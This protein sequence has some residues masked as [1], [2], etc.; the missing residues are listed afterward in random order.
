MSANDDMV[1]TTSKNMRKV[2]KSSIPRLRART[3]REIGLIIRDRRKALG[4]DQAALGRAVGVS[5]QWVI[6]IE[7]GKSRAE[8]GLVLR[9]LN[10]LGLVVSLEIESRTA[11]GV[12][13]AHARGEKAPS[14]T[15]IDINAII[16]RA[17]E[18][19]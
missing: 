12:R 13:S 1:R 5:R 16:D 14:R 15:S 19:R 7:G 8:V 11:G 6:G 10:A 17:R 4:I 18:R 3:A 9:T 2:A